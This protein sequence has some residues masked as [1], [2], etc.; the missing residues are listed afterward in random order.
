[1]SNL[2]FRRRRAQ[3]GAIIIWTMLG[4][5]AMIGAC[6][7]AVDGSYWYLQRAK[8]Q[9][10]ADCAALVY[11]WTV[12]NQGQTAAVTAFDSTIAANGYSSTAL[13]PTGQLMNY[14]DT[15]SY[16]GNP[17]W[18][19]VHVGGPVKPIFG[20]ADKVGTQYID[21][22]ATAQYNSP[23]QMNADPLYYG[24][25]GSTIPVVLMVNGPSDDIREGDLFSA[26]T[27]YNGDPNPYHAGF[28]GYNFQI[29]VPATYAAN[30]GT[31]LQVQIYDPQCADY[32][33][34]T[35]TSWPN[36]DTLYDSDSSF[37]FAL[38]NSS[39]TNLEK[40][41]Y[42]MPYSTS[43]NYENAWVTPSG[44]TLTVPSGTASTYHLMVMATTGSSQDG[45][46]LRAGPPDSNL[47][48]GATVTSSGTPTTADYFSSADSIYTTP[49]YT[50]NNGGYTLSAFQKLSSAAQASSGSAFYNSNSAISGLV[51]WHQKWADFG[52]S[53]NTASTI[54]E[55]D[56]PA[57][58]SPDFTDVSVVSLGA[59]P[60][61]FTNNG[62]AEVLLGTV[63]AGSTSVTVQDFD[64]GDEGSTVKQ[65][66]FECST[67]T[68]STQTDGL[69]HYA[70]T[71][72][73]TP[74][75]M[76]ESQTITLPSNY[77]GGVW[78]A[79]YTS[80]VQDMSTWQFSYVGP[81]AA[82]GTVGLISTTTEGLD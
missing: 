69:K 23:V 50:S 17:Y 49:W 13:G 73:P 15:T 77:I 55:T 46:L 74:D 44:F 57:T 9:R 21:A 82:S 19:H 47:I 27:G 4:L 54:A 56:S 38:D 45:F 63:P 40:A 67:I 26:V 8:A 39:Y 58:A 41:T 35:S 6:A 32:G 76:G 24:I 16:D 2:Q 10:V 62:T 78:T 29:N 18:Y 59:L 25:A 12:A 70:A 75:G 28:V 71:T 5:L 80:S 65:L 14:V 81:P 36:L 68:D 53:T 31:S 43:S 42:T 3:R 60:I 37:Q 51:S 79:S 7:M 61:M 33:S 30:F 11:A 64:A 72:F 22:A 1:M 48:T 20:A 34:N 52:T 66:Y